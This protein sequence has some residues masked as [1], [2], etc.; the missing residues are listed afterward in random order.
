MGD[1]YSEV[2]YVSTQLGDFE[3]AEIMTKRASGLYRDDKPDEAA[4]KSLEGIIWYYRG[5]P[6]RA[7]Q[8]LTVAHGIWEEIGKTANMELV[9]RNMFYYLKSMVAHGYPQSDIYKVL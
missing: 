8:S 1:F 7:M 5:K 2:A 4:I 9:S 6:Q 3:K